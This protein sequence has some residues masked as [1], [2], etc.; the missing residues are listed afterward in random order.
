MSNIFEQTFAKM[1]FFELLE[2]NDIKV[3]CYETANDDRYL[4]ASNELGNTPTENENILIA[5]YSNQD[6]F[7]W[8]KEFK[9][10]EQLFLIYK[11]NENF[12]KNLEIL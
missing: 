5:C 1:N 12:I 4:I 11:E 3:Y 10:I 9:K 2:E 8:K 7:L 6:V